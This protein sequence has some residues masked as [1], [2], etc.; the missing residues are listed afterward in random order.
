MSSKLRELKCVTLNVRGLNDAEKRSSVFKWLTDVKSDIIFLQET[1]CR[2]IMVPIFNN[3]WQGRLEHAV[4]DSAYSRGVSI[5]FNAKHDIKVEN[6]HASSDGRLL[7]LNVDINGKLMTLVNIYAH[8]V[9]KDRKSLFNKVEKWIKLYAK[10]KDN[11]IVAG[12]INCCLR[13]QDRSKPTHLRDKSRI[14]LDNIVKRQNLND[15]WAAI[16]H[17][18][19]YTYVDK[20]HGT[21]SRLDYIFVSRSIKL[22]DGDVNIS[23]CPCVPDHNAVTLRLYM[24]GNHRGPGYWKM[25]N[26]LLKDDEFNIEVKNV[27]NET[28]HKYSKETAGFVWEMLKIKVKEKAICISV[29]RGKEKMKQKERYQKELDSLN[30]LLCTSIRDNDMLVKKEELEN[31]L[32]DI[33][34][35][36]ARG[37]QLRSKAKYIEKGETSLSYFKGL[38]KIHQSN[39]VIESVLGTDGEVMYDDEDIMHECCKF[40]EILYRSLNIDV[41]LIESYINNTDVPKLNEVERT[42]C[43]SEINEKEVHEAVMNLK[44]NRSPGVDGIT[45]EFYQRHWDMLKVPYMNMLKESYNEGELPTTMNQSVATLIFKKGDKQSL[46]NY[47]PIS[48][49][50]YDYKIVAFILAKR[51]QGVIKS[52]IHQDQSAYIKGR[53]IGINARYIADFYSYC[54]KKNIPGVILSLD[55]EKAFDRLEWNFMDRALKA[56]NFGDVFIKWIQILYKR[57]QIMVK[58]NGWISKSINTER[59]IRQGCPVSALLFILSIELMAINIRQNMEIEGFQLADREKKLSQYADDSTLTLTSIKSI[60][61]SMKTVIDFCKVSGMKLNIEKTE[62]IWLGTFKSNPLYYQGIKF[63]QSCVRV[64]GIYIGHDKDK[65][66][67]ENWQSKINRLKNSIHVWKSRKLSLFGKVQILKSLALSKFVYSFTV[68]CVPEIIIKELTK[69]FYGF[70]WNKIDRIKR[71]TLIAEYKDGGIRMVDVEST[72]KALKAA[73]IPR[74]LKLGTHESIIF[75]NLRESNLSLDTILNGDIYDKNVFPEN[76]SLPEFYKDCI[77]CF[78]DCKNK[79]KIKLDVHSFL[80]QPIWCNNRFIVKGKSMLLNNWIRSGY[81]YVR[82]L[83]KDGAF[84]KSDELYR[85][86]VDKRNWLIEYKQVKNMVEKQGR[87]YPCEEYAK[88]VNVKHSIRL[89]CKA[90]TYLIDGQTSKFFYNLMIET[91]YKRS[92]VERLWNKRLNKDIVPSQWENIYLNRIHSLPDNKLRGFM[93]KILHNIVPS[94]EVLY[95]WKK[96]N[97]NLCPHCNELETIE[98]IY[99]ECPLV[100][101]IWKALCTNTKVDVNWSKIIMGYR[102]DIPIHYVR[103]LLFSI[104]LYGRYKHWSRGLEETVIAKDLLAMILGDIKKWNFVINHDNSIRNHNVIRDIWNKLKLV[105]MFKCLY[106]NV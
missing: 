31:K 23:V 45:A 105:E 76:L 39:N 25:N 53:Y 61:A 92:F 82:D 8:N 72:V 12:D 36:E 68:L 51:L 43:D 65:C 59:G 56:F 7:L 38:E 30:R 94:R 19:G 27:V 18:P 88:Y 20:R 73:W 57:P 3:S 32:R 99:F 40:Y 74:L 1:F 80:S 47:R 101:H 97:T 91:K 49:S 14:L 81:V 10:Y 67:V 85:N 87:K 79:S 5:L 104:V 86:L 16:T 71:N 37:A 83:Y 60:D 50:N 24:S 106:D 26:D 96:L 63:T 28:I 89:N 55:F 21:L 75:R 22:G 15:A 44:H 41:D 17:E 52:I 95:K 103:N 69:C 42:L 29:K 93:Y 78:N 13:V 70:L 100:K 9:E 102:L 54:E 62:G 77:T 98:H 4:T 90:R 46:N 35:K 34:M 33:Y 58:N 64:L 84:L 48:L 66:Y 6:K 11:L 2:E